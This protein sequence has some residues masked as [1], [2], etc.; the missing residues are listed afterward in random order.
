[1]PLPQSL[2]KLLPLSVELL[3]DSLLTVQ[4]H[5]ARVAVKEDLVPAPSEEGALVFF[6]VEVRRVALRTAHTE[7]HGGAGLLA[8]GRAEFAD[9]PKK[10]SAG[11]ADTEMCSGAV[12]LGGKTGR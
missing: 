3:L 12:V 9:S 6:E 1:L 10:A 11:G 7:G 4:N 8:Q 2:F 5:S